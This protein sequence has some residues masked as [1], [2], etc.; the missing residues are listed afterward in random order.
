MRRSRT[1]F[2]PSVA[3]LEARSL[4]SHSGLSPHPGPHATALV[5]TQPSDVSPGGTDVLTYHY[6]T[7]RTGPTSTRRR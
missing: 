1:R 7:S 2:L 3:S 4:L 6:D 5:K